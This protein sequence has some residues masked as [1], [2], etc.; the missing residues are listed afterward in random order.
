MV[1]GGHVED[2]LQRVAQATSCGGYDASGRSSAFADATAPI[3]S[4]AKF[5]DRA[6][7]RSGALEVRRG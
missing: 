7:M 5:D 4:G 1:L 3:W 2:A 6:E